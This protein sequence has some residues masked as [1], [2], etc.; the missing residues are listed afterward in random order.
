[1]TDDALNPTRSAGDRL[2]Q[3]EVR[4]RKILDSIERRCLQVRF[5]S[6]GAQQKY[7]EMANSKDGDNDQFYFT[8]IQSDLTLGDLNRYARQWKL[9]LPFDLEPRAALVHVLAQ[10][11]PLNPNNHKKLHAALDLDSPDLQQ[12]FTQLYDKP[13]ETIFGQVVDTVPFAEADPVEAEN[14]AY[15]EVVAEWDLIDDDLEWINLPSGAVLYHQGDP[16]DALYILVSGRL[17]LTVS[18][19]GDERMI[20]EIARGEMVGEIGALTGESHKTNV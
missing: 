1:M 4:A 3:L 19:N 5:A 15:N 11:Y 20:A 9:L 7:F 17:R 13:F 16:G 6:R 10:K 2:L 18:E 12:A 8:A 14:A